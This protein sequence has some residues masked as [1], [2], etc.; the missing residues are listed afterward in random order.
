VTTADRERQELIEGTLAWCNE[1][2]ARHGK[3]ALAELPKGKRHDPQSCPC[4]NATGVHVGSSVWAEKERD[5]E[6]LDHSQSTPPFRTDYEAAGECGPTP[7]IVQRFVLEFDT[8]K[9]PEL[10]EYSSYEA[11]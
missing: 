7:E 3:P 2:R 4:G 9:L 1:I 8:G 10:D 5:L 11:P 6:A